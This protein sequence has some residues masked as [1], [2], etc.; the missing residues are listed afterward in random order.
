MSERI[1]AG[2]PKQ[3]P[4]PRVRFGGALTALALVHAL[5][6]GVAAALL[7]WRDYPLFGLLTSALALG[8]LLTSAAALFDPK[9]VLRVWRATA[10]LATVW[11]VVLTWSVATS[12]LYVARLYGALGTGVAVALAIDHLDRDQRGAARVLVELGRVRAAHRNVELR[13]QPLAD[14][15]VRLAAFAHEQHARAHFG[16]VVRHRDHARLRQ[17]IRDGVPDTPM[18]RPRP[19]AY[20]RDPKRS[21][22]GPKADRWIVPNLQRLH[23]AGGPRPML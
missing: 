23:G 3:K 1:T 21:P 8:H 18:S 19:C 5:A 7:P 16:R 22:P 14:E 15:A 11:L 9:R 10:W 12:A 4:A 20:V 2:E 6:F 13:L 17:L